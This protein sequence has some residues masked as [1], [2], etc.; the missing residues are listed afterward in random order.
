MA[1][2][3][4]A[5]YTADILPIEAQAPRAR[6]QEWFSWAFVQ[7]VAAAAGLVADV[8]PIDSNQMDVQISTWYPLNGSVR[9]IALQLKSTY[10]PEF[11]ESDAYVVHDLEAPR[12]NRLLE[13]SNVPRFFVI[14]AVPAPDAGLVTCQPDDAIL[15]ATAWWGTVDGDPVDDPD[16]KKK[17]V[18]LPTS[19]RFDRDGLLKM[20]EAA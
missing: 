2:H 3:P 8:K 19:Q 7:S 13:P 6:W 1:P 18:K 11:V 16:S 17:R 12:Y 4:P 15:R 14:V 5:D 20:L 10:S 9:T